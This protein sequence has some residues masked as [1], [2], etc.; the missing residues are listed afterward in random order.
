MQTPTAIPAA[1]KNHGVSSKANG[2]SRQVGSSTGKD[3]NTGSL[4]RLRRKVTIR[5]VATPLTPPTAKGPLRVHS[6]GLDQ[7]SLG[8]LVLKKT[9]KA[10]IYI[11]KERDREKEEDIERW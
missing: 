3:S 9:F 8:H 7:E 4:A 1:K 5:L 11:H 10:Y 6:G 2:P